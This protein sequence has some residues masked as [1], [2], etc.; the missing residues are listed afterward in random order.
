MTYLADEIRDAQGSVYL[1]QGDAVC[2]VQQRVQLVQKHPL[3]AL[4]LA[5]GRRHQQVVERVAKLPPVERKPQQGT[6]TLVVLDRTRSYCKGCGGRST[7]LP[8]SMPIIV[9]GQEG[10]WVG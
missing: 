10:D 3:I 2:V 1:L 4:T 9:S 6:W 7:H 8:P 5:G